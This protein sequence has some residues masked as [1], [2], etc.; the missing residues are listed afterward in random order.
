MKIKNLSDVKAPEQRPKTHDLELFSTNCR[1]GSDWGHKI[2][3]RLSA[4]Y[5][6]GKFHCICQC[7]DS[8]LLKEE[9]EI[10][11][12]MDMIKIY[13]NNGR[14]VVFRTDFC[15]ICSRSLP[16]ADGGRQSNGMTI[17]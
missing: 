13:A 9:A 17:I 8:T 14:Y 5:P 16:T 2:I 12:N 4:E 3:D 10:W 1:S 15:P 7:H 11:Q 6:K